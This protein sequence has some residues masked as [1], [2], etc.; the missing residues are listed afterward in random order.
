MDQQLLALKYGFKIE[1]IKVFDQNQTKAKELAARLARQWEIEVLPVAS[2]QEAA[3]ADIVCT[4]TPSREPIVKK[5]WIK[6]GTHINAIGADAAGKEEL[7]P[8]LLKAAKIV[9]DSWAQASH[10]GEINVPFSKGLIKQSD[11]YAELG[12]IVVGKKTGRT[13]NAEITIF[14][15]TGLAIQDISVAK[16]VYDK[17]MQL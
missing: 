1:T 7:D 16:Y 15:S 10:S 11:I 8:A 14:D 12:E 9:V 5:E 13:S 6:P 4:T 17:R 2:M 3:A